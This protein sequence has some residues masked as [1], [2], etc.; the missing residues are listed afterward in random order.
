MQAAQQIKAA[1]DP[2][3]PEEADSMFRYRA[4]IAGFTGL[5][6]TWLGVVRWCDDSRFGRWFCE[7]S[8]IWNRRNYLCEQRL[9][10][11]FS[12]DPKGGLCQLLEPPLMPWSTAASLNAC[13][14]TFGPCEERLV[15]RMHIPSW[16]DTVT[17][18]L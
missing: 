1:L 5:T 16:K 17:I 13:F 12:A 2:L 9:N 10:R 4:E 14:I 3:T 6:S 15:I 18:T 8:S 11:H 7:T